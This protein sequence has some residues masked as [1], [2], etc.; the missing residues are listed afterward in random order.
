MGDIGKNA[1]RVT[2]DVLKTSYSYDYQTLESSCYKKGDFFY[3]WTKPLYN[4]YHTI[5]DAL[6]CIYYYFQ[7]KEEK[8]N[9]QLLINTPN[10]QLENH[11]PFVYELLDLQYKLFIYK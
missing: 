7:L 11:P 10:R 4:Y 1:D 3:L 5:N 8:P 9:L 6:G 2:L